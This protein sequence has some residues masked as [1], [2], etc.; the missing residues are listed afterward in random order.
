M[1]RVVSNHTMCDEDVFS[2]VKLGREYE[3]GRLLRGTK[4]GKT[5]LGREASLKWKH[6]HQY[7]WDRKRGA[8]ALG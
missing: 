3:E 6:L 7:M 2:R 5:E 1:L 8:R 4:R